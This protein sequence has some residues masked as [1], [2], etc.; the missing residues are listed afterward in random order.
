MFWPTLSRDGCRFKSFGFFADLIGSLLAS[1]TV[2]KIHTEV[3][4]E[5]V[6]AQVFLS[7]FQM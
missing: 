3:F 7:F 5:T 6:P 4:L 2:R 1:R